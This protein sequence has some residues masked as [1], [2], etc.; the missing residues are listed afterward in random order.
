MTSPRLHSSQT[1]HHHP[2]PDLKLRCLLLL[3]IIVLAEFVALHFRAGGVLPAGAPSPRPVEPAGVVVG[4]Y[5]A[6]PALTL[7]YQNP[8]IVELN[9]TLKNNSESVQSVELPPEILIEDLPRA[10][11][12]AHP[13]ELE[14]KPRE[15]NSYRWSVRVSGSATPV[16]RRM[17]ADVEAGRRSLSIQTRYRD[18]TGK[19][20][21]Q[22]ILG[23]FHA[24]SF[25]V[26]ESPPAEPS[27]ARP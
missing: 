2:R 17:M 6:I 1:P 3:G 26:L 10:L 11:V 15:A 16:L 7:S 27:A 22:R 25:A 24:G 4:P 21:T 9:L 23:R 5:F 12:A 13:S 14:M 8:G 19:W 20:H 18:G